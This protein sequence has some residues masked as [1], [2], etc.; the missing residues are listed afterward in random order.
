[1]D[2]AGK[3]KK[4]RSR[5]LS[6]AGILAGCLVVF[7]GYWVMQQMLN[8]RQEVLLSRSGSLQTAEEEL[9]D[10]DREEEARVKLTAEELTDVLFRACY[11]MDQ[12]PHEPYGRQMTMQEAIEIGQSWVEGFCEAYAF[13]GRDMVFQFEE[14][15]ALLCTWEMGDDAYLRQMIVRDET[16]S[17]IRNWNQ[18]VAEDRGDQLAES[19]YGYWR[20]S[21]SGTGITV[22]LQIHAVSGQILQAYLETD[23]YLAE[24]EALPFERI[25][26]EYAASFELPGREEPVWED[27]G[28]LG[29]EGQGGRAFYFRKNPR[30]RREREFTGSAVWDDI[31]FHGGGAGSAPGDAGRRDSPAAAGTV[32]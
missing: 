19:M 18:V 14:V 9:T 15:S 20:I 12:V 2:D 6:V 29:K 25:L 26:T 8:R 30:L 22:N 17:E 31:I 4:R 28:L 24:M 13:P 32:V 27:G 23:T 1:M 16:L 21:F 3:K 10:D 5:I 11:V 7:A